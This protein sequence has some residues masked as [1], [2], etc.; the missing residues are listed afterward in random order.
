MTDPYV[1]YIF[2][3]TFTINKKNT[4][5]LASFFPIHT[6]ILWVYNHDIMTAGLQIIPSCTPSCASP[7]WSWCTCEDTEDRI[8]WDGVNEPCMALG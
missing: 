6:W 1:C 4:V 8:G 5:M 3:V 7:P 2:M